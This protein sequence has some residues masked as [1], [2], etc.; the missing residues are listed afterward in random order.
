MVKIIVLTFI[1]GHK[2]VIVKAW[3]ATLKH[4][5]D[6]KNIMYPREPFYANTYITHSAK[7]SI[8]KYYFKRAGLSE[9]SQ[10]TNLSR[11]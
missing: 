11:S 10:A 4:T 8:V 2:H 9:V 3:F 6:N 7:K 5:D 1:G